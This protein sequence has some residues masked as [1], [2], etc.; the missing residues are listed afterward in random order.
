MNRL[1][2]IAAAVLLTPAAFAADPAPAAATEA[3]PPST[4]VRPQL[5]LD[6][7]GKIK[8]PK[9]LQAQVNVYQAC[10]DAYAAERKKAVEAHEA[11]AKAHRDA[12]NEAIKQF[13][14]LVSEINAAQ[15]KKK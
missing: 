4:C 2:L 1:I 15:Q 12:G 3:V 10:T 14:D 6:A 7:A 5:Q 13:N 8:D 11:A 9:A